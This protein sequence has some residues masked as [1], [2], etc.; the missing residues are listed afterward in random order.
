MRIGNRFVERMDVE[1]DVD[2][3]FASAVLGELSADEMAQLFNEEK[4]LSFDTE[5]T[6]N[7]N[8]IECLNESGR[9]HIKKLYDMVCKWYE[10][11]PE[12]AEAE[13]YTEW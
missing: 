2:D 11:N 3:E 4:I 8:M 13:G 5:S 7:D 1:V 9:K 6:W 12:D 10:A